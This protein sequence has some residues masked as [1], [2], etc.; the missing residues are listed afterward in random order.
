MC[1]TGRCEEAKE[2]FDGA[3]SHHPVAY[4][5]V[6]KCLDRC[7]AEAIVWSVGEVRLSSVDRS[8]SET[9]GKSESVDVETFQT[10]GLSMYVDCDIEGTLSIQDG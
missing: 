3:R 8:P 2:P 5:D 10:S 7:C 4:N 9:M 6:S 1:S